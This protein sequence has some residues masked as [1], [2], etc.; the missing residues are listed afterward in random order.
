[1]KAENRRTVVINLRR[2]SKQWFYVFG[3]LFCMFGSFCFGV[4]SEVIHHSSGEDLSKGQSEKVVVGSQGTIQLGR[5][6]EVLIGKFECV[7][8]VEPN[9][10]GLEPWSVNSIVSSGGT[11][12]I[13]TSPNG[14]IYRY[15]L[16]KPTKIYPACSEQVSVVK[17]GE[18]EDINEASDANTV[19][20]KQYLS[21]EHI[22]AMATDVSGRLLAGVSGRECK[23]I[24]FKGDKAETIFEPNEARYILAI[25]V[26]AKGDIYL[27]TGPQGKVYRLD[28]LGRKA[29]L[30]YTARDKNILSLVVGKDG[31]VYAGSDG[32]GLVYKIDAQS[33]TTKVLY[34]SERPEVTSL[35]ISEAG[36]LYAAA[37]SAQI[38]KEPAEVVPQI[39]LSGRPE[40][41]QEK[42]ESVSKNT[43]GRE[44]QVA[45][46]KQAI[47]DKPPVG[48]AGLFKAAKPT[49]A[50][51][52]HK[53]TLDGFSTNVF[54]KVAVLFALSEQEGKLLVGTGNEAQLI[55]IDV[56]VEEERIIYEDKQS[57]Q[58]TAVI[59]SGEDVYVGTANP[60]KLIKLSKF[61][62]NEGSYT[63]GLIDAGQP[64]RWGKLQIEADIPKE[65]KVLMACRSG[66]VEDI[67]DPTFSGWTELVEVTEPVQLGC[68]VGR[69]CQ[70]K[71]ILRTK[72]NLESPVVREI[73]VAH[74][75]DNLAPK[76][77]SVN[78]NRIEGGDKIGKFKI[79]Y[80]AK[81]DNKDK[82]IY[83]IDFRKV[84]R[85]GWIKVED[86]VEADNFEW[87]GRAVEDGRYE[88]RV[89]ASDEIS[90]TTATR[91][92]GSRISEYVVV[93]NTG[94]VIKGYSVESSGKAV[95]LKLQVSDEL[96]VIG[97]VSYA[98]DSNS[99][100]RGAMPDDIVYDTM[101]ER[102]TVLIEDLEAGEHVIAV[103]VSD[104][105]GN[106]TYKS[107]E[108]NI[109]I[110]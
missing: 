37:T 25:A 42:E 67:N 44:L 70:Y 52:I 51:Y 79:S 108:V 107:L 14:G 4:T 31:F 61:F 27:G 9:R 39:S 72:D 64:A 96:S 15:Q 50:S 97:E 22:F 34:D 82:L 54:E 74:T 77:E 86:K 109:T 60:A 30:I 98:V 84:G 101:E 8:G 2:L 58:I 33:K 73:A 65:S 6:A 83:R 68:P 20:I 23:L 40:I 90:N 66:N 92:T 63:S 57:S 91:L 26:D 49:Q 55:S 71:L 3:I 35:L 88:I 106:T 78:V 95:T 5:S 28:S 53:V 7:V 93:D 17:A 80:K 11:I 85:S 81:D 16:G 105:V 110:E 89:T 69:F 21:N 48:P 47:E 29:E 99:E 19:E 36:D 12:Y 41:K 102:F 18:P 103:R 43:G 13:G 24:R 76:V 94:P 10:S 100:W 104:D 59:V 87:N 45:N 46:T 56:A 38:V 75:V 1:M 32:R 62:S